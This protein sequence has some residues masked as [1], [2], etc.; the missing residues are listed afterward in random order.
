[1]NNK[2]IIKIDIIKDLSKNTG[3]S[4]NF[5]K[6]LI[7]D[8]INVLIIQIK[9]GSLNLKNFGSF[10]LRSKKE[11]LGRNPKTKKEHLIS[12]RKS[13]IFVASSKILNMLD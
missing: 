5:S 12:S 7:D 13:I 10:K 9:N 4:N 6:K 3:F 8:L 2:N 11:R 1:V